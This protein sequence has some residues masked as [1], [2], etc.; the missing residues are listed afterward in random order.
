MASGD[1]G[2]ERG[3]RIGPEGKV[4]VRV[5]MKFCLAYSGLWKDLNQ[6]RVSEGEW[7]VRKRPVW[8]DIR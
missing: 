5:E 7:E 3:V 2:R 6:S 1:P 4:I 8:P